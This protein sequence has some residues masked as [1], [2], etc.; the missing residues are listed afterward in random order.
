MVD[1]EGPNWSYYNIFEAN[2]FVRKAG[3]QNYIFPSI[4]RQLQNVIFCSA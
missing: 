1:L 2:A 4:G 3:G